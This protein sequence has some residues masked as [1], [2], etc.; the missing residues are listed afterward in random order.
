M[1]RYSKRI[2]SE[3]TA[4]IIKT[5]DIEYPILDIENV[6][7]EIGGSMIENSELV[8]SSELHKIC[9]IPMILYNPRTKNKNFSVAQSLG[10]LFLHWRYCIDETHWVSLPDKSCYKINDVSEVYQANLFARELLMPADHFK[11]V[12]EKHTVNGVINTSGVANYFA[13]NTSMASRRGQELGIFKKD[14]D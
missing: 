9:N 6:V 13:I 3:L 10:H 12:A 5:F 11:K 4:D 14:F 1:Y 2:I 7:K 8:G